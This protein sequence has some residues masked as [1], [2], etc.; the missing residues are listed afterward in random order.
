MIALPEPFNLV[1]VSLLGS[2]SHAIGLF[3]GIELV[4]PFLGDVR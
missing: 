2:C 4:P 3:E 1:K